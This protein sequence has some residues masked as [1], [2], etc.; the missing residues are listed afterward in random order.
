MSLVYVHFEYRESSQTP[1][2]QEI[3]NRYINEKKLLTERPREVSQYEPLT[4]IL[5]SVD[6]E[7][8]D[9]FMAEIS[10]LEL[11]AVKKHA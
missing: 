9:Q 1:I 11:T 8:A 7:Y 6:S 10:A 5:V 2:I 4:K 3:V